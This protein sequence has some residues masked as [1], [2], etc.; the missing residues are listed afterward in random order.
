M[1]RFCRSCD[2]CQRTISK[3]RIP[4][5]PLQKMPLIDQ[6]FKR[7]AV[8]LVGLISPP[9]G[10][11]HQHILTL[12]DYATRYP[13]AIALKRID[14]PTVA[15][16]LVDMFSRLGIP[17][18]ILSDLGTQFVSECMEDGNRLLSIRHLT[19]TPYQPMCNGYAQETMRRAAKTVKQ[20]HKCVALCIPGGASRVNRILAV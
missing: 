1:T 4:K 9:R 14:T 11:G 12:V 13:E 20:I 19:T 7:V 3:G 10:N 15:E 6:P 16:A 2:I 5:V 8:D 17:E 18:E